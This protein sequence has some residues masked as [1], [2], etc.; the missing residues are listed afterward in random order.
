MEQVAEQQ[1]SRVVGIADAGD[2]LVWS[3]DEKEAH[4]LGDVPHATKHL[5]SCWS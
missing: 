3:I 4:V 2:P 1:F 5:N